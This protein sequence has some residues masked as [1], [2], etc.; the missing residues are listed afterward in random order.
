MV[1]H[2]GVESG[3]LLRRALAIGCLT[4]LAG[5]HPAAGNSPSDLGVPPDARAGGDGS[6][7]QPDD[8]AGAGGAPSRGFPHLAPWVSFYGNAT[9]MGDL[10]KVA[11]TFRIINIDADPTT[12]NFSPAQIAQLRA[13][14]QNRVISYLNVGACEMSRSYWSSAPG[15]VACGA[16]TAAQIGPYSG[17]PDEVWMNVANPDYQ[18]LIVEYVAP[19]L[20]AQGVDGFFLDNLE[21]VE[22]GSGTTNGPCDATCAQGGLDLVGKL[23]AAFS[24]RLIVMQNATSDFTRLGQTGGVAYPSLLDGISHEEVTFPMADPR[25]KAELDAWGAMGLMPG[26]RPFF[27]GTED[28]VGSCS[29]TADA[30]TAYQISRAAG[31][32]PYATDKSAGQ[33]VV[34]YWPF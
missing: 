11:A 18:K 17:Y 19:R 26:G 8:L 24:D 29:N 5:C 32:S 10:D 4:A 7:F 33:N 12:N 14:G 28:Y 15:Y 6:S 1:I 22:H 16:N 13:G 2:F 30:Q 31:F 34:C 25:V 27:V 20:A 9:Q 21:L 23:R 3:G